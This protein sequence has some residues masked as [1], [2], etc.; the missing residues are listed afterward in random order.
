MC[1]PQEQMITVAWSDSSCGTLEHAADTIVS[2][3]DCHWIY[4][5]ITLTS[6][7][8]S[9]TWTATDSDGSI[10]TGK[11]RVLSDSRRL[12]T[13]LPYVKVETTGKTIKT[14]MK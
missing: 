5:S 8:C 9:V 14:T 10:S 3:P 1:E 4:N 2:S 6:V 12:Y 13:E 11:F 7:P